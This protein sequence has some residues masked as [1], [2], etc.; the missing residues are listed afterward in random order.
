MTTAIPRLSLREKLAYGM[1]DCGANFIFQTQIT[2]LLFFYTDVVGIGVRAAGTVL[3]VSRILDTI[4]DPVIGA[5]SDRTHS[6]WGRY[7]P[8]ILLSA[9]PLALALVLCYTTPDF[10]GTGK[11]AWAAATYN[12]MMLL[13]AANNIPYCA[14]AGVMTDD[15]LERTSLQSW[16]FLC[17][18]AA[19][20]IV[21]T[22][23]LALIA[24]LGR[25]DVAFGFQA[26][27][28]VWA[29]AAVVCFVLT[30]VGTRERISD[31]PNRVGSLR[32]DVSALVRSRPW[33]ALFIVAMLVHIH[34]ALR[35]SAML[36][37]FK[38]Y[39]RR[40]DLF[41]EFSGLG[42]VVAMIGI[43]LSKP[44]TA[45]FGKRNTFQ[46]CALISTLL[47]ASFALVPRESPRALFALQFLFQLSFGP[48][49]PLLWTMMADV[50]DYSEWKTG[51]AATALAFASIVFGLKLGLGIGA[52]L[53][54]VWLESVGYLPAVAQP[55]GTTITGI[56]LL[57]SVFP[58]A[59]LMLAFL[60]LSFYPIHGRLEQKMRSALQASRNAREA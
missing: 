30:F 48:T 27:M 28:T 13:Y 51:H 40:E 18:M 17:A 44:L 14:L 37:Y 36:Y 41:E 25:G 53:S 2:F 19:T 57:V 11:I 52:W 12:L 54:G 56:R 26:A 4:S 21:N 29:V 24:R 10:G 47:I 39:L 31:R 43:A 3:L 16:R 45:R 5:I 50:A 23:T 7:R 22:T 33:I 42:L 58:A 59:A 9:V 1:G 55:T 32:R 49:I 20:F 6:R 46:M 38:H 60:A 15:S 8:W 35:G 34:L